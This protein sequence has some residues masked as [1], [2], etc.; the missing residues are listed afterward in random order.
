MQI[1]HIAYFYLRINICS[2]NPIATPRDSS[3]AYIDPWLFH[4]GCRGGAGQAF[5]T[6][7]ITTSQYNYNCVQA[8]IYSDNLLNIVCMDCQS[9]VSPTTS[10]EARQPWETTN[11]D[12]SNHPS[13]DPCGLYIEAR[14]ITQLSPIPT[15]NIL[16]SIKPLLKLEVHSHS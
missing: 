14:S 9:L 5:A 16:E 8:I 7:N 4:S 15:F 6:C 2:V 10:T 11:L 1:Q 3:A 12:L 13:E